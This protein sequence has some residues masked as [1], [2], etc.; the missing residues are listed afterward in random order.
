MGWKH[1]MRGGQLSLIP[2]KTV[3]CRQ[4]VNVDHLVGYYRKGGDCQLVHGRGG[5]THLQLPVKP[6]GSTCGL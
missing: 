2:S 1:R 6:P 4:L 5:M 3:D